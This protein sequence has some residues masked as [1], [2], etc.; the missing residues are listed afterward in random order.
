LIGRNLW[1]EILDVMRWSEDLMNCKLKEKCWNN[2]R[3]VFVVHFEN[4]SGRKRVEVGK[5]LNDMERGKLGGR[6]RFE[7]RKGLGIL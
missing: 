7:F 1:S 4:W 5:F 2:C 6:G 3:R